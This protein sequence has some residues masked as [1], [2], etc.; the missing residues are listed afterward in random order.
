MTVWKPVKVEDAGEDEKTA[1]V[2]AGTIYASMR[3]L[4]GR[5]LLEARQM[6]ARKPVRIET[7]Y[8]KDLDENCE[9]T[10]DGRRFKIESVAN[11]GENNAKLEIMA[12]ERL[13]KTG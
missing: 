13:E 6:D 3:P 4:Q 1:Y 10:W 11:D 8:R 2:P 12:E 5:E 7:R 9:L